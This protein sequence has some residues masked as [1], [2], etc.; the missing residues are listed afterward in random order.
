M[1]SDNVSWSV[2]RHIC[3]LPPRPAPIF[4]QIET[5][6]PNWVRLKLSAQVSVEIVGLG[7]SG[8][9]LHRYV[10]LPF[11]IILRAKPRCKLSFQSCPN[12]LQP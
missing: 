8:F 1:R 5:G 3:F 11:L 4:P 7:F 10:R 12:V 2:K 6:D 9:V